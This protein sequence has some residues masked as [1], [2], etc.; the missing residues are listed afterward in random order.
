MSTVSSQTCPR[1][2][3]STPMSLLSSNICQT[4][5]G[6]DAVF[7]LPPALLTQARAGHM[8]AVSSV[9]ELTQITRL[10][11]GPKRDAVLTPIP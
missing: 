5:L 6:F 11:P 7:R 2:E 4:A 3:S 10:V 9:A 1:R 8:L